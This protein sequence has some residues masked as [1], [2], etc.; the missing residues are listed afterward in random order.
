MKWRILLNSKI[1]RRFW[2]IV[3]RGTDTVQNDV[4]E[5][6]EWFFSMSLG[7]LGASLLGNLLTVQGAIAKRWNRRDKDEE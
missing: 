4:K 3:K 5:Q 2:S 7:T 6:K 1:S